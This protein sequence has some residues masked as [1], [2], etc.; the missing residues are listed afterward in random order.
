MGT[1]KIG[2]IL[3]RIINGFGANLICFDVFEADAVKEMGGKYVTKEEIY[4]QSD[5]I[6]LMSKYYSIDQFETLLSTRDLTGRRLTF[7]IYFRRTIF[8]DHIAS[9]SS[10][11]AHH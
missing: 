3:C 5:I 10:Y 1:G 7:L 6:F 9:P 4:A 2:Q 11:Q 8:Y